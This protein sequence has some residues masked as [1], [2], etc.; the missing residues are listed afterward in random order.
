MPVLLIDGHEYAGLDERA[1]GRLEL[2]KMLWQTGS[3]GVE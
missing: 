2:G 1:Q 3:G